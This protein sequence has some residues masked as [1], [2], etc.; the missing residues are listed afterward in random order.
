MRGDLHSLLRG[1]LIKTDHGSCARHSCYRYFCRQRL[2]QPI[3][4]FGERCFKTA[5]LFDVQIS[6]HGE[7]FMASL[8][9]FLPET[10]RGGAANSPDF[11]TKLAL[12][13]H[14]IVPTR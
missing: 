11:P 2:L 6:S 8:V 5:A 4:D 9:V 13:P 1:I 3:M 14:F 12:A 7:H 10:Q